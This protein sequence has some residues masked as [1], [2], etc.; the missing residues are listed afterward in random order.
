[1]NNFK[2]KIIS[3][4]ILI[5]GNEVLSGRTEDK[6]S[7]HIAIEL[8]KIGVT[9]CEV[10]IIGDYQTQIIK[11]I[12][13]LRK[14]YDYLF[15]TGG[16]G[17]THDDI[18]AASAAKALQLKLH[19]NQKA[20]AIIKKHYHDSNKIEVMN[21]ALMPE[22]AK[23]LE[24]PVTSA[25]GFMIENIIVMAGVPII[26]QSM[27][28]NALPLIKKGD[29]IYSQEISF[30]IKESSISDI[31]TNLQQKNPDISIGSY[32]FKGGVSIVFRGYDQQKLTEITQQLKNTIT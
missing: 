26:M 10:R 4:A 6:N 30:S 5:I 28:K 25:P 17:S 9:L 20:A 14:K 13:D 22:G 16:I 29:I 12:N 7:H 31:L 15:T 2:P 11:T 1:M 3:A 27:L 32:P 8:T 18:T 21:M 19:Q 23:L 24:N